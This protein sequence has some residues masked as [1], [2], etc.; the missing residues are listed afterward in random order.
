MASSADDVSL[1]GY[2]IPALT[3]KE[4]Y[5]TWRIN[6]KDTLRVLDL[7][8]HIE[9]SLD[10]LIAANQSDEA[11]I[12]KTDSKAIFQMRVRCDPFVQTFIESVDTA[13]EIWDTL[14]NEYEDSRS[15]ACI[16]LW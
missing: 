1:G 14:R 8:P 16:Y 12:R 15:I 10:D 4:N 11:K 2:K 6:M 13:K 5:R 7:L 9:K 3:G